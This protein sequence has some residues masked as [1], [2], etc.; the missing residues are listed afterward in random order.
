MFELSGN[1]DSTFKFKYT[2]IQ[3]FDIVSE[4]KTLMIIIQLQFIAIKYGK[5]LFYNSKII[6][7]KITLRTWV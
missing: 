5:M 3:Y 6:Q 7:N 1:T 2:R 4:K